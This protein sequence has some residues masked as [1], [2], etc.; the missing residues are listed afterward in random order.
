MGRGRK[1]KSKHISYEEF[2]NDRVQILNSFTEDLKNYLLEEKK[3]SFSSPVVSKASKESVEIVV[4]DELYRY[5]GGRL[6]FEFIMEKIFRVLEIKIG[7]INSIVIE[8]I[9]I[10]IVETNS[11]LGDEYIFTF[12][13][14]KKDSNHE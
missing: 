4:Y 12:N 1:M 10:N 5:F 13:Y 14:R 3:V 6:T 8:E 2:L 11:P 9:V 7:D